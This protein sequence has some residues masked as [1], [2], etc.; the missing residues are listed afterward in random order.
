MLEE[1]A[2]CD[3]LRKLMVNILMNLLYPALK[4]LPF[5][6]F[7]AHSL[8][9]ERGSAI[10]PAIETLQ[11]ANRFCGKARMATPTVDHGFIKIFT[12]NNRA[13]Q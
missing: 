3:R 7:K 8:Q 13:A 12:A 4:R 9:T 5:S 2:P 10:W 1:E 11:K 6:G